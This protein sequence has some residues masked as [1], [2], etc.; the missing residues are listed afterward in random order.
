MPGHIYNQFV[1]DFGI[2]TDFKFLREHGVETEVYYPVPL[3]MQDV[4]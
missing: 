1:F 2:G 3:H 4:F